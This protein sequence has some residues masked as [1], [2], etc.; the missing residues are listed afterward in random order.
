MRAVVLSVVVLAI[1]AIVAV[2]ILAAGDG[3][4]APAAA[5]TLMEGP[6]DSRDQPLSEVTVPQI[7]DD[8]AVF[9]GA[10]VVVRG[11]S[12]V[13]IEPD[14]GFVLE[15]DGRGILVYTRGDEPRLPPGD[16]AIRGEVVRFTESAAEQLGDDAFSDAEQLARIPTG[17][18]DPY[19]LFRA[20]VRAG[21][22]EAEDPGP[23]GTAGNRSRLAD[24][25]ESPREYY[26]DAVT[27]AGEVTRAGRRAFVLEAERRELLIVPQFD[28]DPSPRATPEPGAAVRAQGL[29]ERVPP[30]DDSVILGERRLFERYEGEPSLSATSVT[31]LE[32]GRSPTRSGG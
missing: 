20:V 22:G 6:D 17:I 23:A 14:G 19:L 29:V 25:A 27:V 2:V 16:V 7:L 3:N 26:G 24:I 30:A 31:V 21:T 32:Q 10:D 12:I 13:P 11:A 4:D 1:G 8:P 28:R 18:G 9:A 5:P 15:D